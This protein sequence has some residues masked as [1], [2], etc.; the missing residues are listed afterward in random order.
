MKKRNFKSRLISAISAVI[1]AITFC[2]GSVN[3]DRFNKVEAAVISNGTYQDYLFYSKIDTND[4]GK[5]DY[6]RINS[7]DSSIITNGYAQITIPSS[8]D[9]LPVKEIKGMQCI[10]HGYSVGSP[11]VYVIIPKSVIII[12]DQTPIKTTEGKIKINC[13]ENSA[14]HMYAINNNIE[15]ELAENYSKEQITAVKDFLIYL[16]VSWIQEELITKNHISVLCCSFAL[17]GF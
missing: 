1:C 4:N 13:Y 14:A 7:F 8:I 12:G 9:G 5:V 17:I 10:T 6:I 2:A 16:K 3:V 11:D 15:F